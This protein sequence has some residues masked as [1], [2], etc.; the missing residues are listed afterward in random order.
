V[1]VR[2]WCWRRLRFRCSCGLTWNSRLGRCMDDR[3]ATAPRG[4][5]GLDQPTMLITY[6]LTRGQQWRAQGGQ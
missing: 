2:Y 5:T 1:H 4:I 3:V 6:A